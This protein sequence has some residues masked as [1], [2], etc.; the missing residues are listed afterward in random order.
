MGR[1]VEMLRKQGFDGELHDIL[2]V[3][4]RFDTDIRAGMRAGLTTCLVE[5]GCHSHDLQNFY[6]ADSAH[7]VAASVAHLLPP[8]YLEEGVLDCTTHPATESPGSSTDQLPRRSVPAQLPPLRAAVAT[9]SSLRS[10]ILA[11]GNLIHASSMEAVTVPLIQRLRE[12]FDSKDPSGTGYI[13]IFDVF[14]ALEELGIAP[15]PKTSAR[16]QHPSPRGCP[17][18]PGDVMAQTESRKAIASGMSGYHLRT[19]VIECGSGSSAIDVSSLARVT[20]RQL[21]R[22]VQHCMNMSA[23]D[24]LGES[25]ERALSIRSLRSTTVP[26]FCKF[27]SATTKAKA[28]AAFS[29]LPSPSRFCRPSSESVPPMQ[30]KKRV[31][32]LPELLVPGMPGVE[33]EEESSLFGSQTATWRQSSPRWVSAGGLCSPTTSD[34]SCSSTKPSPLAATTVR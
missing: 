5:T 32:P 28:V 29:K 22:E 30:W 9:P 4:D 25:S 3:G 1:A 8:N 11:R 23:E 16:S 14:Q 33:A 18:I 19:F 6:P 24:L 20:F 13:T 2:I 26:A 7:F 10:W 12:Y 21:C 15:S 34:C 31:P 27:R 17:T